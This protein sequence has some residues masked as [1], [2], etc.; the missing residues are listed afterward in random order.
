MLK[1]LATFVAMVILMVAAGASA[2]DSPALQPGKVISQGEFAIL[3]AKNIAMKEPAEGYTADSA[4]AW[5]S[6]LSNPVVPSEGWKAADPLTEKVMVELLRRVGVFISPSNPEAL[7]TEA[8]A[9]LAFRRYQR[10]F[11]HYILYRLNAN[12]STDATVLD[13]G[14]VT[15][16]VPMS[17]FRP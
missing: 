3:F 8:K 14:D 1:R 12:N 13:E 2:A 15:G 11:K 16:V 5:L 9:N 4:I 10:Q 6:G 7:V 17:G